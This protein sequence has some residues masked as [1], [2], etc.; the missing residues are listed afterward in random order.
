M[1]RAAWR[2]VLGSA[3]RRTRP[4]LCW[5]AD[6]RAADASRSSM[7]DFPFT[8]PGDRAERAE[9]RAPQGDLDWL[10]RCY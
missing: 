6:H 3:R 10:L 9:R 1:R 8:E 4:T 5:R 7:S 2:G